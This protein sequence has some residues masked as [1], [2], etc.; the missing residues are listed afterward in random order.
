VGLRRF[1]TNN[2][3]DKMMN[4]G[5]KKE[6]ETFHA[7]FN[8]NTGLSREQM[9]SDAYLKVGCCVQIQV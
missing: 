2:N 4:L 5:G 7:F 8:R 6:E 9:V 3:K 1:F